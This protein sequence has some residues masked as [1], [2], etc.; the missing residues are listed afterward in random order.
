[1]SQKFTAGIALSASFAGIYSYYS[2]KQEDLEQPS[3]HKHD[4]SCNHEEKNE[5]HNADRHFQPTEHSE[6]NSAHGDHTEL[7]L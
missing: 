3:Q 1:L 7:D 5:H 6:M 4:A 2:A